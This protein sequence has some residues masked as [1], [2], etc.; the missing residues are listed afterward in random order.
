M[1]VETHGVSH[2]D[3]LGKLSPNVIDAS[4]INANSDPSTGEIDDWVTEGA[5]K[6]NNVITDRGGAPDS[7]KDDV[8]EV[9]R[10]G[11]I[12]YAA[13]ELLRELKNYELAEEHDEK[14]ES[15]REYLEQKNWAA[16]VK[17]PNVD[18]SSDKQPLTWGTDYEP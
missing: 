5:G 7:I 11:V 10:S 4:R 16:E 12:A 8:R 1:A 18:T 14:F 9:V 17:A 13:A 2:D 15:K 6:L 3:V